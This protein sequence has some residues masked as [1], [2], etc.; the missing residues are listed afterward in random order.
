M[1]KRILNWAAAFMLFFSPYFCRY[2][3]AQEASG[4][5]GNIEGVSATEMPLTQES[6]SMEVR[7]MIAE[8]ESTRK[9]DALLEGER[10]L[11]IIS[12]YRS[13]K[14]TPEEIRA[15][16]KKPFLDVYVDMLERELWKSP[17]YYY[18]NY[19]YSGANGLGNGTGE[20]KNEK[21]VDE[22]IPY[23][24]LQIAAL[25]EALKIKWRAFRIVDRTIKKARDAVTVRADVKNIAK[26]EAGPL[27]D[28]ADAEDFGGY[29]RISNIKR[30]LFLEEAVVKVNQ[31][32]SRFGLVLNKDLF[33]GCK[34]YFEFKHEKTSNRDNNDG[35]NK[36]ESLLY[37]KKDW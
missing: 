14:L 34:G 10:W 35:D 19:I 28:T 30:T 8:L 31:N 23:E 17:F 36:L 5:S 24:G 25:G 29:A 11:N 27:L 9:I 16:E 32:K 26:V 33:F 4:G 7:D 2:L 6:A 1:K 15:Y 3:K 22:H 13:R 20:E 18:L 21:I 37:L 12:L